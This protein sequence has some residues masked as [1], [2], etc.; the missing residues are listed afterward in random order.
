MHE[1]PLIFYFAFFL[2]VIF[3][4][5]N[6]SLVF[7]ILFFFLSGL[8]SDKFF[9]LFLKKYENPY[10]DKVFILPL[11]NINAYT[12]GNAILLN[13][14]ILEQD[15]KVLLSILHHEI[16]H[17]RSKDFTTLFLLIGF[18]KFLTVFTQ[19]K[20]LVLYFLYVFLFFWF[21]WYM[22]TKADL[23]A[24]S[25]LGEDYK[26]TLRKFN[27]NWR[28][29]FLEGKTEGTL[30][31]R[32]MFLLIIFLMGLYLGWLYKKTYLP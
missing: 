17:V 13:R 4:Y 5:P 25:Q 1:Y 2:V 12:I 21:Y 23:Y 11:R 18:F 15:E 9:G 20:A 24:Y 3:F 31:Q 26:E 28:L 7:F 32:A 16:G 8:Y 19:G 22:E 10:Y 30:Q 27:I 29:N 6:L 14:G